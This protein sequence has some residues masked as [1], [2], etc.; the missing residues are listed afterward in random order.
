[1]PGK[2]TLNNTQKGIK[3]YKSGLPRH[4][5][6]TP[7]DSLKGHLYN[8][9]CQS[10]RRR[11]MTMDLSFTDFKVLIAKDCYYC[12]LTPQQHLTKS[13]VDAVLT[14]NGIDRVDN[15]KPYILD[16]CVP[17]CK[18]CNSAKGALTKQAFYEK[19]ERLY[20]KIKNTTPPPLSSDR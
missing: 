10:M 16:N 12:G 4:K 5:Y 20:N 11:D 9:Y 19:V 7:L 1:M 13:T 17:C 18:F 3:R 14:Y 8:V 6:K 15:N 2:G